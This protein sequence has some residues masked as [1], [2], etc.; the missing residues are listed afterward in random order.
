MKVV[1][2]GR[3]SMRAN[4]PPAV[5]GDVIELLSNNWDDYGYKTS[6]PVTCRIN[7]EILELGLGPPKVAPIMPFLL[8][9][10][11]TNAGFVLIAKALRHLISLLTEHR[12]NRPLSIPAEEALASTS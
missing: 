8:A 5:E 4:P 3:P 6:F 12:Q 7:G 9:D 11:F 1:Y 2:L 10:G